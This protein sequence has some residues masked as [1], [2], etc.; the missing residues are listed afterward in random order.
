MRF[1]FNIHYRQIQNQNLNSQLNLNRKF[2]IKNKLLSVIE[3][4]YIERKLY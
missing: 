2:L 3:K 1:I 4:Y